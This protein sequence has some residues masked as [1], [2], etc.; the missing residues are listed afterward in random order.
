MSNLPVELKDFGAEDQEHSL[1]DV[2]AEPTEAQL[3]S[4][5]ESKP[6]EIPARPQVK[7]RVPA[8]V[9]T[10]AAFVEQAKATDTAL[11]DAMNAQEFN[12]IAGAQ[13]LPKDKAPLKVD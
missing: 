9:M 5:E 12:P 8:K 7:P 4:A 3:I 13:V 10:A 6:Q 11:Y 1:V 2:S